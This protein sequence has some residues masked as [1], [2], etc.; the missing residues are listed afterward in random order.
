MRFKMTFQ[1]KE[2][3]IPAVL[4]IN[5]QYA[6][7]SFVYNTLHSGNSEL[8]SWLHDKGFTRE[9]RS[10]RLFSFSGLHIPNTKLQGDRLTIPGDA[11]SLEISFL[12]VEIS[13]SFV[14]GLF[15]KRDVRLGDKKSS[16]DFQISTIERLPDPEFST[17]M[18]FKA[19]TP[20]VISAG[21]DRGREG[22]ATYLD[23][24]AKDYGERVKINLLEKYEAWCSHTKNEKPALAGLQDYQF[25]AAE[26]F[27]SRLI[28]VKAGTTGES[29]IRGFQYDFEIT[30]PVELIKTGY[31][32][33]FGEKNSMGFG[34][35]HSVIHT[36]KVLKTFKT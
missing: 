3:S 12:P 23:P 2:G 24:A 22:S 33:G 16:V 6:L 17:T 5:Y 7:S 25:K 11:I 10:F 30:A 18:K 20:V 29:K 28:T 32:A 36:L 13:E 26:T 34:Y 21:K 19:V 14:F 15:N 8:A 31:Y 9:G 35:C 27:K 4:P 1:K